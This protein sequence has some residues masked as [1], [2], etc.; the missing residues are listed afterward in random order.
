VQFFTLIHLL[1]YPMGAPFAHAS[2]RRHEQPDDFIEALLDEQ[3]PSSAW[4]FPA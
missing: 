3:K 1:L 2:N 4:Q